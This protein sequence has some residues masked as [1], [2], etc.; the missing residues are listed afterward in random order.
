V[1]PPRRG[2]PPDFLD[3]LEELYGDLNQDK[4]KLVWA[5]GV[6]ES[7]PS[8]SSD[9]PTPSLSNHVGSSSVGKTN[10]HSGREYVVTSPIKK[11]TNSIEDS[12]REI[13]K[14]IKSN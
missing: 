13:S 1:S 8:N 3:Q 2:Q 14:S 12:V 9:E 11:K 7:T 5:G 10:K 4:G 6:R